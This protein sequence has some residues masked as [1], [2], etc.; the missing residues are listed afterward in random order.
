VNAQAEACVLWRQACDDSFFDCSLRFGT[1]TPS[2][3]T[4]VAALFAVVA[5]LASYVPARRA[6]RVDPLVALRSE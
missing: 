1:T 4:V 6:V 2:T 5:A 3:K